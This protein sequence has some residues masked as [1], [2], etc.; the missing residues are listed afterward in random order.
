MPPT[1]NFRKR[2]GVRIMLYRV[3]YYVPG[4]RITHIQYNTYLG[5]LRLVVAILH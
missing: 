2:R 5:F 1:I 4:K 3:L